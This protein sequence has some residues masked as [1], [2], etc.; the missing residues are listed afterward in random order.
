MQASFGSRCSN[1]SA[2]S[3]LSARPS[4]HAALHQKCADKGSDD[5]DDKVAD[6]FDRCI[7]E[8]FHVTWCNN[9]LQIAF[10]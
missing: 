9:V 4:S 1:I 7:T 10:K 3:A 8:Y 6:F 5:C 2:L